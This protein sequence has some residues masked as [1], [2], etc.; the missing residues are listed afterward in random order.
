[1]LDMGFI[2]TFERICKIIPFTRQTCSYRDDPPE[3]PASRTSCTIRQNRSFQAGDD[4]RGRVAVSGPVSREP[5]ESAISCAAC[6]AKPRISTTQSSSAPQARSGA[7]A[8]VAAEARLHVGALHGDMDQSARTA[9]LDQFRKGESLSW[10]PPM[11][12]P[13]A[14][15][16][17]P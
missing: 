17:R 5:H 11:S 14:S 7:V 8:Q 4:R 9:A 12:P 13:A 6:C 2:P 15:T 10:S 1:M 3:S 16:F